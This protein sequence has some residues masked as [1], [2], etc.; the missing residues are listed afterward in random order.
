MTV[1]TYT[2]EELEEA[3]EAAVTKALS[4]FQ[5]EV[6]LDTLSKAFEDAKAPLVAEVSELQGKLDAETL[7]ADNAEKSFNDL[8]QLLEDA[9]AE[10]TASAAL[11]SLREIRKEAL[12]DFNFKP[13][14]VEARLDRWAAMSDEDFDDFVA[15]LKLVPTAKA[16]EL[17]ADDKKLVTVFKASRDDLEEPG[18]GLRELGRLRLSGNDIRSIN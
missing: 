17:P 2:Q 18:T 10:A 5:E 3:V 12:K 8:V 16:S 7:R 9:E 6:A 14:H 13:E 11:A 4:P 1:Q 15:T